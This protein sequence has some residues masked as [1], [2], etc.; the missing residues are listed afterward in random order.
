LDSCCDTYSTSSEL[1][2][3]LSHARTSTTSS[4]SPET[5]GKLLGAWPS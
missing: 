5:Y 1:E 4:G 2:P 3:M